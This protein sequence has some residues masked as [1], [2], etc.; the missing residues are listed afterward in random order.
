MPVANVPTDLKGVKNQNTEKLR[1]IESKT[2]QNAGKAVSAGSFQSVL[3]QVWAVSAYIWLIVP[4]AIHTGD[5]Q[6]LAQCLK[7]QN[8]SV[9][10]ATLAKLEP[11]FVVPLMRIL[12]PMVKSSAHNPV[13]FSYLSIIVQRNTALLLASGALPECTSLHRYGLLNNYG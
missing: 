7:S 9:L 13:L 8:Q 10:T 5:K 12:I 1:E 11:K 4:Q 2:K 3:Q 6:L